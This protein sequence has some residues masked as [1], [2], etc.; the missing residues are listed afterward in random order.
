MNSYSQQRFDVL[1]VGGGP[2]GMAAAVSAA[3]SGVRVGIVDENPSLGGQIWRG[4][5]S[6]GSHSVEASSWLN[7]VK[8]S[9]VTHLQGK[10]VFHQPEPGVLLAEGLDDVAELSY[11]TL[12]LATGARERFLPFPGWTLPNVTG[13]GGLQAL[14]KSGLPI[15]GKRVVVAG[16]GPLLLAV[17]AYLRKHGAEIPMICEQASWSRLA[18]FGLTLLSQPGKVA[19]SLHLKKDIAGISFVANSWP[20]AAHGKNALEAVTISRSGKSE[21]VKCDY[22]ACGFHLVPNVELPVLMGCQTR[23]G[24]VQVN[25]LQQTTVKDIFCAG[26]PTGVGGVEI[27]LME[28]Q[29][30]GL[31]ATGQVCEAKTL[32][33]KRDKLRRFAHALDESFCLRSELR[34]LPA[35]DT[36]VCRCEDVPYSHLREHTCWRSAK[37]HTR[38]GMGPCQGRICGPATQF[39]FKWNPDS[40]RPPVFPARVENLAVTPASQQSI[41]AVTGGLQ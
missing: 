13:A 25:D 33:R 9:S 15:K 26:E 31:A 2:A 14:V 10:R 34:S 37:L 39:L 6:S 20:L 11:R 22:L 23:C 4:E 17:A 3:K 36:L 7:Q 27:A 5:T 38:C 18:K 40:V 21:V 24:Y 35:S 16:T 41:P 19:Q 32:F 1:I 8:T 30:A 29:I 12:V 28:G